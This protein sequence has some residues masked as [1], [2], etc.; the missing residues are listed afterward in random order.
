MKCSGAE[1]GPPDLWEAGDLCIARFHLDNAWHRCRAR[2]LPPSARGE[3]REVA[4]DRAEARVH[5]V[6]Y[7]SSSLV[8]LGMVGALSSHGHGPVSLRVL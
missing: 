4:R 3:V 1:P 2:G 5:F 7:G 6:D 8:A